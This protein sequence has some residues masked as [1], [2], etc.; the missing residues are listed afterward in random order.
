MPFKAGCYNSMGGN[1]IFCNREA[2]SA[3]LYQD[4]K[5]FVIRDINPASAT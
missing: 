2:L 3:P 5:Y 4:D 1:C